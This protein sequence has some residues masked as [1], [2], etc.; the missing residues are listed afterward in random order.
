MSTRP[1]NLTQE[2]DDQA[3]PVRYSRIR[4]CTA[5]VDRISPRESTRRSFSG[6]C[7]KPFL[8]PFRPQKHPIGYCSMKVFANAN[9]LLEYVRSQHFSNM[10]EMRRRLQKSQSCPCKHRKSREC[11]CELRKTCQKKNI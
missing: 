3:A 5:V 11:Q 9:C 7:C 6:T 2:C 8:H 1:K 4:S 10:S